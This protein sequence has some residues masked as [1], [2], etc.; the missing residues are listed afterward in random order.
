M[1]GGSAGLFNDSRKVPGNIGPERSI[2]RLGQDLQKFPVS[3]FSK[4]LPKAKL[5]HPGKRPDLHVAISTDDDRFDV[6]IDRHRIGAQTYP[7]IETARSI[8]CKASPAL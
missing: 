5:F 3:L 1:S 2:L 7:M 8:A 4:P 6:G